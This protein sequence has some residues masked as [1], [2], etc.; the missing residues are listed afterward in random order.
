MKRQAPKEVWLFH[1]GRWSFSFDPPTKRFAKRCHR[2]V[3]DAEVKLLRKALRAL[4]N[5]PSPIRRAL[6]LAALKP[7]KAKREHICGTSS[8]DEQVL[9]DDP[10]CPRSRNFKAK[11]HE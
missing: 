1:S 7:R 9:C 5:D 8:S 2:M 3:P 4:A 11:R 10:K 6:A